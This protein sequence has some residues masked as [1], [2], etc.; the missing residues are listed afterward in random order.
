MNDYLLCEQ[1]DEVSVLCAA[2]SLS[3]NGDILKL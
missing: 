1:K 2:S 3:N